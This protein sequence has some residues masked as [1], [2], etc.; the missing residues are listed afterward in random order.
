MEQLKMIST[1]E[2]AKE[3]STILQNQHEDS[4]LIKNVQIT[5]FD[6]QI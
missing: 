3:V 2:S 6:Y 5:N 4:V 1:C